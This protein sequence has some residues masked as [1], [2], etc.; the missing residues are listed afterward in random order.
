MNKF[1][2]W[3]KCARYLTDFNG[4]KFQ[5][6]NSDDNGD[7]GIFFEKYSCNGLKYTLRK[8][9]DGDSWGHGIP[10]KTIKECK[11]YS[12]KYFLNKVEESV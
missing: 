8:R 12:E 3:E 2:R 5:C 1:D 10:F 11:E 7:I 6:R 9:F 4:S